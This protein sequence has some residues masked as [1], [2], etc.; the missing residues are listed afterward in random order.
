MIVSFLF[1]A[2]DG[3]LAWVCPLFATLMK[4]E[5]RMEHVPDDLMLGSCPL[6]GIVQDLE[7][8]RDGLGI[9][10]TPLGPA[11]ALSN[12]VSDNMSSWGR[13]LHNPQ[14]MSI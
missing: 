13:V 7:R 5:L 9:V 14:Q 8:P 12:S 11:K 6:G 1:Q 4:E 2:S 3:R 10:V